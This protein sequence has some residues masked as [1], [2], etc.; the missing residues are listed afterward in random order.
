MFELK[1]LSD[2][3]DESLLAELRRVAS[4]LQGQRIT[5]EKF[6]KLSRVPPRHCKEGS[7]RLRK[8]LV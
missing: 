5:A 1:T 7:V 4:T 3:S 2:Y 6:N 8:R